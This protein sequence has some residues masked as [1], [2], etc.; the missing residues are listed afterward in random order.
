M[1]IDKY[2]NNG[3]LIIF[4]SNLSLEAYLNFTINLLIFTEMFRKLLLGSSLTAAYLLAGNKEPECCGIVGIVMK[5][6]S[7]KI[8]ETTENSSNRRYTLEEFLCEGVELLKNRGY[9]S[10]GIYTLAQ[11]NPTHGSRLVKYADEG[12]KDISCINRVIEEVLTEGGV[13]TSGIAHTRWATCG[14]RVSRN[15][16]PHSD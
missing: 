9:D 14:E 8:L 15:A 1:L 12:N 13:A 7:P 3:K 5:E 10:A 11:N 6:P 16:H 4:L 2:P